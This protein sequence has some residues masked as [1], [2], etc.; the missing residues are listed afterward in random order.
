MIYWISYLEAI[1]ST[2]ELSNEKEKPTGSW[3]QPTISLAE[4]GKSIKANK[5][6]ISRPRMAE[7]T[8]YKHCAAHT[9]VVHATKG[10]NKHD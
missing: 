10:I 4:T 1:N 9:T 5:Y 2:N 3:K 7:S 8:R 6:I